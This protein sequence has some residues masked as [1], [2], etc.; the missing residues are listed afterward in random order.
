MHYMEDQEYREQQSISKEQ[1]MRKDLQQR[2][3]ALS[4]VDIDPAESKKAF[5]RFHAKLSE[6]GQ[7]YSVN[8]FRGLD[9]TSGKLSQTEWGQIF[10]IQG[11]TNVPDLDPEGDPTHTELSIFYDKGGDMI[12]YGGLTEDRVD[13]G[14]YVAFKM[15]PEKRGQVKADEVF[16]DHLA[17]ALM[18]STFELPDKINV[19]VNQQY[20]PQIE[21]TVT[22]APVF[23][24]KMG[25]IAE[26]GQAELENKVNQNQKLT[27]EE[28]IALAKEPLVFDTLSTG[29]KSDFA[30]A[31]V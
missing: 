14:A 30:S 13:G 26:S 22:A 9:Q 2:R 18:N 12:G 15:L 17:T 6:K 11:K 5:L 25:F 29:I 28:L 24:R 3:D 4:F 23:Y 21:S 16:K 10:T 8:N 19:P 27:E 7:S 31:R 20:S 1:Q